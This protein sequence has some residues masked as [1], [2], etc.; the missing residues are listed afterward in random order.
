M[1]FR[2]ILL[3]YPNVSA[4]I[5]TQDIGIGVLGKGRLASPP[6]APEPLDSAWRKTSSNE[7]SQQPKLR[8]KRETSDGIGV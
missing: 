5:A 8:R 2:E 4:H 6:P 3:E 7:T 1:Q